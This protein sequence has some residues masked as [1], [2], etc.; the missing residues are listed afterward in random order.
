MCT[1]AYETCM[2]ACKRVR[3]CVC[4]RVRV[5]VHVCLR[6]CMWVCDCA[7][8]CAGGGHAVRA[9]NKRPIPLALLLL[10]PPPKHICPGMYPPPHML[11]YCTRPL[12]TPMP[13]FLLLVSPFIGGGYMHVI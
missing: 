1:R 5:C 3:V 4:A 8:V 9:H 11:F 10:A 2:H 12:P 7:S 13:T 6:V